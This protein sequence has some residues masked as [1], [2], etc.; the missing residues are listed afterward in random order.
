MTEAGDLYVY[1]HEGYWQCMDT[2]RE[3]NLLEEL[4]TQGRAPWLNV[5]V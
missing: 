2:M 3:K 4:A 1:R 5:R